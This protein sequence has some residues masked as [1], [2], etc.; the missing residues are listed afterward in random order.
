MSRMQD[1]RARLPFGVD[2][3]KYSKPTF[4]DNKA[5]FESTFGPTDLDFYPILDLAPKHPG[6]NYPENETSSLQQ[7]FEYKTEHFE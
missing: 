5:N 3:E 6:K 2:Q 1:S 4:I 7:I